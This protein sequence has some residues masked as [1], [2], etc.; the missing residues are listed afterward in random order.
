MAAKKRTRKHKPNGIAGPVRD[1]DGDLFFSKQD[2]YAL[3]LAR[4]RMNEKQMQLSQV[5]TL[6]SQ[7]TTQHA[8]A[9]KEKQEEIGKLQLQLAITGQKYA[10]LRTQLSEVYEVDFAVALYD[11]ESGRIT[12]GD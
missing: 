4:S 9:M 2:L 1:K 8:L 10:A 3:E 7:I 11:D 5:E 12:T 6:K